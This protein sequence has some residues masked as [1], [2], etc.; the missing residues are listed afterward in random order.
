MKI[1]K[2][3][4]TEKKAHFVCIRCGCEFECYENEYWVDNSV[5]LTTWPCQYHAMASCPVCHRICKTTITSRA[6]NITVT[7]A[8]TNT[9]NPCKNDIFESFVYTGSPLKTTLKNKE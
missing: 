4:S 2:N 8:D 7:G 5:C 6:E 1:I 9:I 3:G